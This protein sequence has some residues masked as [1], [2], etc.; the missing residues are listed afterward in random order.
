MFHFR[1]LGDFDGF[2]FVTSIPYGLFLFALQ[3]FS[4]LPVVEKIEV[5]DSHDVFLLNS[6]S[7]YLL[8][9][10]RGPP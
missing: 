2:Y 1:I 8:Q 4:V 9:R 5:K 3:F 10:G 7:D 6:E